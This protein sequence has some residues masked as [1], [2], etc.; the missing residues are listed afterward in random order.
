MVG[1][2]EIPDVTGHHG[3]ASE[4]I[5]FTQRLGQGVGGSA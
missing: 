2:D 4:S 1:W 5:S 3:V